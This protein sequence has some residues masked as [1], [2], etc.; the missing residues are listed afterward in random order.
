MEYNGDL[1]TGTKRGQ[2]P[3][4]I[5]FSLGAAALAAAKAEEVEELLDELA[6][7]RVQLSEKRMQL[8]HDVASLS[9]RSGTSSNASSRPSSPPD[10]NVGAQPSSSY[11]K[12]PRFQVRYLSTRMPLMLDKCSFN[13]SRC[14][15]TLGCLSTFAATQILCSAQRDA[16]AL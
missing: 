15:H 2:W 1:C 10:V 9:P 12:P 8:P 16:L 14:P 6:F 13:Q 11:T 7:A 4:H 3:T 5:V